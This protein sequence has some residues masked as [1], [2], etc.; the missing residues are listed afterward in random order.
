ME[1]RQQLPGIS[2]GIVYGNIAKYF[3]FHREDGHTH[4]W[5]LYVRPY[6]EGQDLSL[7]IRK[8]STTQFT[9][10]IQRPNEE[11]GIKDTA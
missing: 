5:K 9:N 1:S 4:E 7:F 11:L 3:G 8:V 6:V 2:R 10:G